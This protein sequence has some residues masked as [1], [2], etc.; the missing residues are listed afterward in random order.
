MS[1]AGKFFF[2]DVGRYFQF[3]LVVEQHQGVLLIQMHSPTEPEPR[4]AMSAVSI[5]DVLDDFSEEGRAGAWQFFETKEQL[6]AFIAWINCDEEDPKRPKIV[7][8]H[9]ELVTTNRKQ[10]K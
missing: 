4:S 10:E 9:H 3:G 2:H 1:L 6:D 5:N 7:S 8:L